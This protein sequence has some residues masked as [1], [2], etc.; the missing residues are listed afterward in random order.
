MEM[1]SQLQCT[2]YKLMI[3]NDTLQNKFGLFRYFLEY[4]VKP[5]L[6][7]THHIR[8]SVHL[9]LLSPVPPVQE[10]LGNFMG[11]D[12]KL[13][14][15]SCFWLGTRKSKLPSRKNE[16]ILFHF[17]ISLQKTEGSFFHSST[18][19]EI[20]ALLYRY[21][22]RN[23]LPIHRI[24]AEFGILKGL[25]TQIHFTSIFRVRNSTTIPF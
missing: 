23:D 22:L 13:G 18:N 21:W 2:K 9:G 1:T 24:H 14:K 4:I 8:S 5:W 25:Q 6:S 19:T 20:G 11:S 3:R 17:S 10:K 7:L 16:V 12:S 15:I